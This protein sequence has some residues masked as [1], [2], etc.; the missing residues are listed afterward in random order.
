MSWPVTGAG[1]SG[2]GEIQ[3]AGTASPSRPAVCFACGMALRKGEAPHIPQSTGALQALHMACLW[4]G[5][6]LWEP[7]GGNG[8]AGVLG[9]CS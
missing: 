9:G 6:N 1:C 5:L 7:M 2:G 8:A 4:L 3:R